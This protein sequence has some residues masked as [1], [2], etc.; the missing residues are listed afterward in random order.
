MYSKRT[1]IFYKSILFSNK[2]SFYREPL[3]KEKRYNC[4]QKIHE[5]SQAELFTSEHAFAHFPTA[6][7]ST[8]THGEEPEQAVSQNENW[9]KSI[10]AQVFLNHFFAISY[11]LQ[12]SEG[13]YALQNLAHF[14][15]HNP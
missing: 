12:W 9:R 15:N 4:M 10:P 13:S 7:I 6:D 8:G 2:E 5:N 11:H 3:S 1:L 14:I